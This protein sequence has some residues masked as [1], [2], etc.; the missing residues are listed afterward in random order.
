[1]YYSSGT[2]QDVYKFGK[3]DPV[4]A[5]VTIKYG[6]KGTL[7]IRKVNDAG[8]PVA[9]VTFRYGA[10]KDDRGPLNSNGD[11]GTITAPTD[12]NGWTTVDIKKAD[13]KIYVQEHT[14]PANLQK[15]TTIKEVVVPAGGT[16]TLTFQNKRLVYI[17]LKKVD[18]ETGKPIPGVVFDYWDEKTGIKYSGTTDANGQ[19]TSKV[20]YAVGTTIVMKETGFVPNTATAKNYSL[21]QGTA[22]EQKK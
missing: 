20:R 19:F 17:T 5:T 18:A 11:L 8:Q 2:L 15:D 10:E 13:R 12:A 7:K 22:A 9:G 21:P 4:E 16:G 14:V 6:A 3:P 1:M